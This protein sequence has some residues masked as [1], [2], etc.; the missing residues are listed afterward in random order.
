M[1]CEL[2]LSVDSRYSRDDKKLATAVLNQL[3]KGTTEPMK[4]SI[5]LDDDVC[6]NKHLILKVTSNDR[7]EEM[8]AEIADWSQY[9]SVIQSPLPDLTISELSADGEWRSGQSVNISALV[10]N[11]GDDATHKDKWADVFYLAEGNT[12]NIDKAVKLGAKTHVRR[13]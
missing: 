2:F 6:G 10:S 8:M 7:Y 4:T 9:F 1:N 11:I 13:L 5:V 3:P 12:L